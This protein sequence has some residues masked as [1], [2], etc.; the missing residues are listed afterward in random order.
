MDGKTIRVYNPETGIIDAE[1]S[2]VAGKTEYD[3]NGYERALFW[4]TLQIVLNYL[5]KEDKDFEYYDIGCAQ[6]ETDAELFRFRSVFISEGDKGRILHKTSGVTVWFLGTINRLLCCPLAETA[7][8]RTGLTGRGDAWKFLM[9][10]YD[11]RSKFT[12]IR[13]QFLRE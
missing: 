11:T 13:P 4:I 12:M 6:Y 3:K 5:S 8:H 7:A 1:R 10:Y 2:F 9:R